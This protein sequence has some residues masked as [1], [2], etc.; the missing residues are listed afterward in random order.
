MSAAAIGGLQEIRLYGVLGK[1]FGRVH[2][3]AVRSVREAMQ[4]LS[5]VV[6]GFAQHLLEHSQPGYHVFL[7]KRGGHS[8]G[9]QRL[10]APVSVRE[11]ICVVPVVA[12]AKAAGLGQ[13]LL[14]AALIGLTAWNPLGAFSGSFAPFFFAGKLGAYLVLG[15]VVQAIAAHNTDTPGPKPEGMPS[16]AFDGVQN[17]A[18][19][20]QPVPLRYGRVMCGGIPVSSGIATEEIK[21]TLPAPPGTWLQPLPAEEPVNPIEDPVNWG[22][23]A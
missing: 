4:A 17:N 20:G 5:V 13:I 21:V 8:V 2:R 15:G 9:E 14:G 12:G 7:G 10:D 16:Y 22:G 19:E 6:P 18:T 3:L 23:G 11:P 1:K